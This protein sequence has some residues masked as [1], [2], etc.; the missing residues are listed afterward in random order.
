MLGR[1]F[2]L[3]LTAAV[4]LPAQAAVTYQFTGTCTERAHNSADGMV[5]MACSS[6]P[7]I[8]WIDMPDDYVPGTE[9]G[10]HEAAFRFNDPY[11]RETQSLDPFEEQTISFPEDL[12]QAGFGVWL[13]SSRFTAAGNGGDWSFTGEYRVG[14]VAGY[15]ISGTNGW[16]SIVQPSQVPLPGTLALLGLGLLAASVSHRRPRDI[17]S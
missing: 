5:P 10:R 4:A 12:T 14:D 6:K 8:A 2:A 9:V 11:L 13:I 17:A 3:G 15:N 7:F 16:F 1:L